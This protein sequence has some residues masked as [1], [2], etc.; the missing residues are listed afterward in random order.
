MEQ[1]ES[2]TVLVVDDDPP[3]LTLVAELLTDEGYLVR[4]VYDGLAALAEIERDPPD[5]VVSD[6]TMPRLDGIELV[7]EM[8]RH[9]HEVPVVLMSAVYDD[10]DLPGVRFVPKPFGLDSLLSAIEGARA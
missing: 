5:V 9:G 6:V 8:R 2:P 4:A 7:R 1:H 10:V 3:I